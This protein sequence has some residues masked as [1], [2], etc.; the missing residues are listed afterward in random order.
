MLVLDHI[1]L[2]AATLEEGVAHAEAAL[3]LK[4][5]GGGAHARMGTHNRLIG[6]GDLYFEVIAVD[7]AAPAPPHPRWFDLDRFAGPPRLGNWICRCDDLAA[8][9]APGPPGIGVPMAFE[10]GDFRWQMAVPA[11]GILPFDNVF[12]ALIRWQGSAHPAPR[13]PEA[14]LRLNRLEVAH[15]E[16][17]ALRAL[18]ALRLADTR[19][20]FV[21]GAPALR[22]TFDTPQGPRVLE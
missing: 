14:G 2:A 15:P 18:L 22:A 4:L 12:P 17:G 16:A 21:P 13:L 1:A 5:A 19:V 20:V 11:T 7:P 6:M 8:E 10:R 3:G 9:L